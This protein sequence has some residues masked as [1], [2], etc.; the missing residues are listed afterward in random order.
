MGWAKEEEAGHCVWEVQREREVGWGGDN[1][2]S[3]SIIVYI[4]VNT[5][6]EANILIF[7]QFLWAS[8][9]VHMSYFGYI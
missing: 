3:G 6:N 5:S 1:S 9:R 2:E 7:F 4:K 8:V